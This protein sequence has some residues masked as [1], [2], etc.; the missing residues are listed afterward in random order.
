V[1]GGIRLR[2]VGG[3]MHGRTVNGG[4][5]ADLSGARWDGAGLDLET[6]NGGVKLR[7]PRDYSAELEAGTTNGGLRIGFPIVV[8]GNLTRLTRNIVTT[9][10]SGGPR[11][12]LRTVN[13]AV[14]I[15]A[16]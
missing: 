1:N 16:L 15:D 11:L 9:L 3:D 6:T 13:G 2:D 4:I 8:Q 12:R 10:G 14:T 5:T 7:L